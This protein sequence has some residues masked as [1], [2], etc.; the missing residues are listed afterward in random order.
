V[1]EPLTRDELR[2]RLAR[3]ARTEAGADV[4]LTAYE[5]AGPASPV[6]IWSDVRT[7]ADLTIWAERLAAAQ[8][9]HQ[10]R[11]Y[12]YVF[13]WE[14]AAEDG[15]LG[16]CHAVDLPFTFG[17]FDVDGWGEFVGG[18]PDAERV[19][20]ELR[21]AWAAFAREGVPDPDWAPYDTAKRHTRVIGRE[22]ATVPDPRGG[23][24]EAWATVRPV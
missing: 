3:E 8:S 22:T 18:G 20:A 10:P 15:R 5:D 1:R 24:R 2:R 7:D 11:T 4:L 12:R 17:T 23:I 21:A 9:A 16:A 19:G 6:H 14:A 13:T